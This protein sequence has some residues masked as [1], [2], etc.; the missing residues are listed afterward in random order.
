MAVLRHSHFLL[1]REVSEKALKRVGHLW[2]SSSK[3]ASAPQRLWNVLDLARVNSDQQQ[4]EP[5]P[6]M[7]MGLSREPDLPSP[8]ISK[9]VI[10]IP[11]AR[12]LLENFKQKT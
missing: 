5:W 11:L 8:G 3:E 7:L 2:L 1:T 9:V 6:L 4:Q 12:T 10:N